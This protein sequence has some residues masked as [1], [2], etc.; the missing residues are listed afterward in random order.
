MAAVYKSVLTQKGLNLIAKAEAGDTGIKFTR[1]VTGDGEYDGTEDLTEFTEMKSVKQETAFTGKEYV[2]DA[3]VVL[4]AI[5]TNLDLEEGY[6]IREIGIFAE[7]PDEG[8]I[9]YSISRPVGDIY[10]YLP[11]SSNGQ[12]SIQLEA[13]TGISGSDSVTVNMKGALALQADLEEVQE[14]VNEILAG[15]LSVSYD[16]EKKALVFSIGDLESLKST[17]ASLTDI[18]E[19]AE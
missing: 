4:T 15:M 10:D 11:D 12:V 7:D 1:L 14:E 18:D 19:E 3:T 8:E 9:L 2:E 6:Y 5:V 17:L 13:D 16:E